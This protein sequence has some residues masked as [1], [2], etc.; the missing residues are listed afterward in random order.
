[1]KKIFIYD[2]SK[3]AGL[4]TTSYLSFIN[5]NNFNAFE[6]EK[7]MRESETIGKVINN[8]ALV[9]FCL[10]LVNIESMY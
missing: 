8:N 5:T 6:I 1:M 10:I 4:F 3:T 9:L 2:T 7:E